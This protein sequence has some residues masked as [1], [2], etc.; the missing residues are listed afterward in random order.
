MRTLR[1]SLEAHEHNPTKLRIMFAH[2]VWL[3]LVGVGVPLVALTFPA[4]QG[5]GLLMVATVGLLVVLV[6]T[7]VTIYKW[8]TERRLYDEGTLE[9]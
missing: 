9:M 7:L 1:L 3:T 2:L 6:S 8:I 5:P 4:L